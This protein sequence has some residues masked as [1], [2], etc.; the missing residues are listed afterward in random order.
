MKLVKQF[1]KQETIRKK[2]PLNLKKEDET[3]FGNM[4]Y[5][6][7]ASGLYYVKNAKVTSI[8]IVYEWFMA[9]KQFIICYEID[10]KNYRFRYLLKAWLTFKKTK[11]SATE[12]YLILFDNYSGPNGFAH[13]LCDGLPKLAEL[14]NDL[15][16]Y[17]ALFPWYFKD[18]H[19]YR[20]T[21]SFFNLNAVHYLEQDSLTT[22]PNL[23]IP[24][25]L[26]TTG[27]FNPK[28]IHRLREI[29]LPQISLPENRKE[30]IYISRAK[31]KRRFV[32]NEDEVT[33]LLLKNN[34]TIV[35]TEEYSFKDQLEL[36]HGAKIVVSIHGAALALAMF[37]QESAHLLEFRRE[38]DTINNMY[39]SLCNAAGI[40]YSYLFCKTTQVSHTGNNFN[41]H[42]N[43][44]ELEQA[45][46]NIK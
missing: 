37:M 3:C 4:D 26:A 34:F 11:L 6:V 31:T 30:Y 46:A 40:N 22:V 27:N 14:N 29:I 39:Y 19:F 21:L 44:Q 7:P 32:E 41:L 13:W 17:T 1:Y 10:F 33:R 25:H 42:I 35:Y 8:G 9:L 12:N 36:I 16:A 18:N 2:I 24:S 5:N 43:I 38:H 20:D 45:I 28:N 23:Y 15:K